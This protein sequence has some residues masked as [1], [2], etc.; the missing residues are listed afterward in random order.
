MRLTVTNN[1]N[2]YYN[3]KIHNSIINVFILIKLNLQIDPIYY[4]NNG[5]AN[6]QTH[7]EHFILALNLTFL[8]DKNI[9]FFKLQNPISPILLYNPSFSFHSRTKKYVLFIIITR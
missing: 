6:S 7:F 1:K 9:E 2:C 3:L 5:T 8:I 4:L